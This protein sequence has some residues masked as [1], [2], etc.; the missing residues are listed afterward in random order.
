M[1][2]IV[3][4][5]QYKFSGFHSSECAN[6]SLLTCNIMTE[7]LRAGWPRGR[8]LVPVG[9]RIFSSPHHPDQLWGPPSLLYKGHRRSFLL[10]GG[11]GKSQGVN[12]TTHLQPMLMSRKCGPIHPLTHMPSWHSAQLVKHR[13]NF[14]FYQHFTATYCLHCQSQCQW[15]R[16]QVH[17]KQWY[18][19]LRRLLP[20]LKTNY[21]SQAI[22]QEVI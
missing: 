21:I 4:N 11:G 17:L 2:G 15:R 5:S 3:S 1:P 8:V 16:Q 19:S 7:H 22:N 10:G 18:A 12:L 20:N 13:D 14:T 6:Y 9:S